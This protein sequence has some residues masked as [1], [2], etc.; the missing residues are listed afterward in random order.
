MQSGKAIVRQVT[1]KRSEAIREIARKSPQTNTSNVGYELLV[2]LRPGSSVVR[3]WHMAVPGVGACRTAALCGRRHAKQA[4]AS[5]AP[6]ARF[7][8]PGPP[9][10]CHAAAAAAAAAAPPSP[11]PPWPPSLQPWTGRRPAA[12]QVPAAAPATRA[13]G[14]CCLLPAPRAGLLLRR[15]CMRCT[16]Q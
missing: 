9:C 10:S 11:P 5:L 16:P 2:M 14:S 15:R 3:H 4:S 12:Q 7:R 1:I 6:V 13:P 8:L